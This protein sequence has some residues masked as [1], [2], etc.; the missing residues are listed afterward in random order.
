MRRFSGPFTEQH[1][2]RLLWRAGFGPKPGEA[3]ALAQRGLVGAVRSLTRVSGPARLV[4]PEPTGKDG[5]PLAPRDA[6][7]HDHLWWLDRMV[8]SDQPF[9]ERMTLVWHDWFATSRD[10]SDGNLMLRQNAT[11]RKHARGSF[12]SLLAAVTSDPAMLLWLSGAFNTKWSPNENYARELMELFTL[13]AGASYTERDVRE[14]AR[15]LTGW[16][17]TSTGSGSGR[18]RYVRAAHD[19]GR[20]RIFGRRGRFDW[21][22]SLDLCLAHPAHRRFVVTKLWGAFVPATPDRVTV[23]SLVALY[24]PGRPILPVLEA[25]LMHP[26]LYM[27]PRQVKSPIVQTA[28]LLRA[29]GRAVH[30]ESLSW[31]GAL[32]GQ[33]LFRPPNVAGWD[34]DRWLDTGTWHG[35]WVTANLV[36]KPDAL[37]EGPYP[38]PLPESPAD[39]VARALRHWGDPTISATTRAELER[40]AGEVDR[41]ATARW[42]REQYPRLRQNALRMLIATSPDSLTC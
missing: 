41:A 5:H 12:R 38:H 17:R 36:A 10:T 15:A 30:D 9:V 18:F 28:G 39:A 7:G 26:A 2:E 3:K 19:T 35:R 21:R 37:G 40:F 29:T 8:R 33:Q 25:I 14:H 13:G 31:A 24:R 11:L 16:Q 4:G 27:G 42:Q 32:S 1:A 34:E 6:W 20:K 23:R 22:D